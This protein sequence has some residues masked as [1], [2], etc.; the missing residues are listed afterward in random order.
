MA[1]GRS[2]RADCDTA[3]SVSLDRWR[4]AHRDGRVAIGLS[5]ELQQSWNGPGAA[6][7][8]IGVQVENRLLVSGLDTIG[9]ANLIRKSEVLDR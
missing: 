3:V 8:M 4:F 2:D 6:G 9:V 1:F 7:W 5:G